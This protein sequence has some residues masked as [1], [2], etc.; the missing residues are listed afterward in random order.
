MPSDRPEDQNFVRNHGKSTLLDPSSTIPTLDPRRLHI[1]HNQ[2]R[3][4]LGIG[5]GTPWDTLTKM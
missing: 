4:G 2:G 1:L 3:T 5:R